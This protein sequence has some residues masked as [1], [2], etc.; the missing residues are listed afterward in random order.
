MPIISLS[1]IVGLCLL[2]S[3]AVFFLREQWRGHVSRVQ[4]DPAGHDRDV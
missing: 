1:V 4:R 3:F 2:F